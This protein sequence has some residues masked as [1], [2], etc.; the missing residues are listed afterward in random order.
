MVNRTFSLH[1][2]FSELNQSFKN[3]NLDG[4]LF[5]WS[6]GGNHFLWWFCTKERQGKNGRSQRWLFGMQ[7][8]SCWRE[9]LGGSAPPPLTRPLL[10]GGKIRGSKWGYTLYQWGLWFFTQPD[11]SERLS[12]YKLYFTFMLRAFEL[13]RS[14]KSLLFR[15]SQKNMKIQKVDL[16]RLF[17]VSYGPISLCMAK[18][19]W[20]ISRYLAL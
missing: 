1:L 6:G 7:G 2:M 13:F 10:N 4:W 16:H 11:K 17:R 9:W 8:C 5:V 19:N 15:V 18:L 3:S 20:F 12:Q 14:F